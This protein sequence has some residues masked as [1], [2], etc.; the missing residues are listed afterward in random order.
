MK[1]KLS[2]FFSGA[3]NKTQQGLSYLRRDIRRR[4]LFNFFLALIIL[5]FVIFANS[6]LTATPAAKESTPPKKLVQTFTVGKSSELTVQGTVDKAGII[7]I[8]AQ[9]GGV[10]QSI[11][12]TEGDKVNKGTV[13]ANL[14][15]NYQGDSAPAA[16]SSIAQKQYKNAIDSYP[17][18]LDLINRQRDVATAS[19]ANTNQLR[20]ITDQSRGDTQA[21][22][23][24][25]NTLLNNLNTQIDTLHNQGLQDSDPQVAALLGQKTQLL[26]AQAQLNTAIRQANYST[27]TT[28]PPT[29]L[30]NLQEQ[31]TMKQLDL[32]E[33]SLTLGR[34]IARLQANLAAIGA[35][36]MNP[37]SPISGKVEQVKVHV[38]D[39]ISP[40]DI[41][42]TIAS[43]T[44]KTDVTVSLPKGIADSISK[45]IPST[46]T[47]G[48]QTYKTLPRFVSDESVTGTLFT[49]IFDI[50]DTY[51]HLLTNNESISVSIP[52]EK[53]VQSV[54]PFVPLDSVYQTVDSAYVYVLKNGKAVSTKVD[55]GQVY[56]AYVE[57][58][59]GINDG[60][61]VILSRTVINGDTIKTN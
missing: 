47:I 21:I 37:A 14:S 44:T 55:L 59:R 12:V 51:T 41:I 61:H 36:V 11:K 49:A 16:S 58:L 2:H 45:T 34:D 42:A 52:V 30:A 9:S 27:N 6:L 54:D 19:A 56:G 35:S 10:V 57:V 33:K 32:Q 28:N 4:P 39:T 60:D 24:I 29:T 25:N 18:Q 38:G 13:L 23:D 3:K 7:T 46:L 1:E 43:S 48:G 26:S 50:P 5:F 17:I 31:I 15:T 8:S 22:I 53:E 40:G 20:Q